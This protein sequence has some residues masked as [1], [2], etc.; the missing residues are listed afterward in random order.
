MPAPWRVAYV[1][2]RQEKELARHLLR[3]GI[4][5]YLPLE[6]KRVRR[7]GRRFVSFLP[8]FPGYLFF[9]GLAEERR[10]VVRSE[11]LVAELEV[12]DQPLL[13]RELRTLWRLQE[14]GVAMAP[15]PYLGPGDAVEIVEGPFRGLRGTVVREKGRN[16][17]VVS[18]S[19]LRQSV[20]A[21]FEREVLEPARELFAPQRRPRHAHPPAG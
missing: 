5:F 4:A 10:T 3:H 7:A 12:W 20:A 11:L 18:V 16:R 19:L 15:H 1:R 17:L 14:S 21:E 13:D 8:L 6:E 9:R 2:S